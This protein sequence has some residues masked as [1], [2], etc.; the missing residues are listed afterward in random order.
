MS[1]M[2]VKAL[3]ANQFRISNRG[4]NRFCDGGQL[5]VAILV[6]LFLCQSLLA[7][8]PASQPADEGTPQAFLAN[9]TNDRVAA[10]TVRQMMAFIDFNP[11]SEKDKAGVRLLA[12]S[13]VAV[14]RL[15]VAVRKKWGKDAETAVAHACWDNVPDDA[16]TA[17]WTIT[18]DHAK[19]TFQ[20]DRLG[21]LML[22]KT[23]G[24][25]KLDLNGYRNADGDKFSS[26]LRTGTAEVRRLMQELANIDPDT[27]ADAFARHVKEEMDKLA[28]SN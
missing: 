2:N 15:E 18:G 21:D 20:L 25:W 5:P 22:V 24:R 14:A 8:G 19:A 6:V 12:A 4:F 9:M 26:D 11:D 13:D 23:D 27:T 10:M 28:G 3:S 1:N 17:Q 7:D 16:A